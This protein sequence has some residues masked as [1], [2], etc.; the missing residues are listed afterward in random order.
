MI[1]RFRLELEAAGVGP[2]SVRKALMLLQGVLQRACE[3]GRISS[4]PVM[5]VRKPPAARARAVTPLAPETVEAIRDGLLRRRLVRDATLVS[6]LAYAGLRPAE[7]LALTWGHVRERT[8]LVESAA[9]LGALSDTK[10]GRRRTVALVGPLAQDL[11][12][13]REHAGRAHPAALV[14]PGRAGAPWTLTM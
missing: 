11:T 1:N 8:I 9:S 14:F 13:W 7:A 5:A 3:W 10:T 4:N 6:V 2:A 12:E